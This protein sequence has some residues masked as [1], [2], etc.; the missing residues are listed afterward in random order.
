VRL[1]PDVTTPAGQHDYVRYGVD[2]GSDQSARIAAT[3]NV[4]TGEFFD[5]RR[6]RA[7]LTGRWS[8]SPFV[9]LR[10]NYEINRLA[11]LGAEGTSVV[12]HLAEPDLRVFAPPRPEADVCGHVRERHG[13]APICSGAQQTSACHCAFGVERALDRVHVVWLAPMW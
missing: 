3:A 11:S 13:R 8:S 2:L 10:A 5:G 6:Q 7:A 9:A 4:S 1:F 12:T